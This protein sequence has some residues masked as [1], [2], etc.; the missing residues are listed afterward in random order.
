[1]GVEDEAKDKVDKLAEQAKGAFGKATDDRDLENKGNG[2]QAD[3]NP[4]AFGQ[5]ETDSG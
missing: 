2:D 5:G 1:M 4:D 3:A